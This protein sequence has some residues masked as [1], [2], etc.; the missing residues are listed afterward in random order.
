MKFYYLFDYFY[1][2]FRITKISLQDFV[3]LLP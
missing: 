1:N 2:F 3:S